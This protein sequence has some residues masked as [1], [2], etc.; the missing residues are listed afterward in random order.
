MD[1]FESSLNNV[2]VDT[3]NYILKFEEVSLKSISDLGI[4]VSEAHLLEAIGKL[5]G[6]A[7]VSEV[8]FLLSIAMPTVTVAVKKL[9]KKGLVTKLQC[10]E[11]ARR[12]RI[13]LTQ[14]GERVN[15]A[16]AFF[17]R[18][19]VRNISKGFLDSEKQILL[20][21]IEKLNTFFKEKIEE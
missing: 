5:N 4:T 12:V 19:M 9:E 13:G 17:H 21:A 7:T 15:K 18:K 11:D 10:P 1:D 20:T 2:L 6:L 16:H 14:I 3:F 8:A